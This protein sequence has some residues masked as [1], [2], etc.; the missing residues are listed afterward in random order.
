MNKYQKGGSYDNG[1][2]G[3]NRDNYNGRNGNININGKVFYPD[4]P[5]PLNNINKG[6]NMELGPEKKPEKFLVAP[7]RGKMVRGMVGGWG[8]TGSPVHA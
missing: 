8:V 5:C 1:G 6:N 4:P 2:E 3:N 7:W